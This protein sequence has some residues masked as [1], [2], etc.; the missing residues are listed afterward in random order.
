VGKLKNDWQNIEEV[1]RLFGKNISQA[2]RGYRSFVLKAKD[3]G[4]RNDLTGG[5]L[6][7]S[8]GGWK[9]VKAM[10]KAKLWQKSDERILGDG[11]FVEQTLASSQE[12]LEQKYSLHA[13][14]YDIDKVA[15]R[16]CELLDVKRSNI[17]AP[18][19]ERYRVQARSLLCFWASRELRI[20]QAELSRKF[21]LSPAAI[22]LCVK[23]GE[24]IALENEYKLLDDL[25][26]KLKDVP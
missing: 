21:K 14:G 4:R 8:V 16:V 24:K 17:W 6:V 3:Q 10:R 1:L 26:A 22:S 23:R 9:N 5:G 25:T 12:S 18:G 13:R 15:D 20:S 2:R 11:D 19:K 7:R